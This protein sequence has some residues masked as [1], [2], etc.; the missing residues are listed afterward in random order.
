MIPSR[1]M[2]LTMKAI[3]RLPRNSRRFACSNRSIAFD[4]KLDSTTCTVL[5]INTT[6]FFIDGNISANLLTMRCSLCW[7]T[8]Q[9]KDN[10]KTE[11]SQLNQLSRKEPALPVRLFSR[12]EEFY[13]LN[14]QP[15]A[16][17]FCK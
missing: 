10:N 15:I 2:F 6:K 16:A 5:C 1:L 8:L 12:S 3:K 11:G 13:F 17:T 14:N 4:V 9:I 7:Q